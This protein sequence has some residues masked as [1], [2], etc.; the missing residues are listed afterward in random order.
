METVFIAWKRG[1]SEM[2]KN[3]FAGLE[4]VKK[5]QNNKNEQ[6]KSEN[7]IVKVQKK[8]SIKVNSAPT[9]YNSKTKGKPGRPRGKRSNE[10]FQQVTAYVQ[11]NT[12]RKV[13]IKLLDRE[14]KG[15]FSELVEDL[16]Q[17]W[18]KDQTIK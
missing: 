15:E 1:I 3:R 18:L 16:L 6:D 7:N 12:Y 14:N 11:R 10:N 9:T 8:E 4:A 17:K 5:I 2:K 13:S